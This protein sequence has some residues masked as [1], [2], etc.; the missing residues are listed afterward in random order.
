[1]HTLVLVRHGQSEW[2]R[3]NLFTGWSDVDLTSQGISEARNAGRRL[4]DDGYDFDQVFT[5]VLKRAIRT[6]W[7]ILDEMDRLW[8]P[9]DKSWR[10]NERHYGA[11]QGMNKTDAKERYGREQVQIWRRS[12][13]TRPPELPLADQRLLGNDPRYRKLPAHLLP[14]AECLH[15]TAVRFLPFWHEHINTTIRAGQ[16]VLIVAHGNS[17]RALISYLNQ[18]TKDQIMELNIPTGVPL[19][20]SLDENSQPLSMRYLSD[21][22]TIARSIPTITAGTAE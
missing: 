21:D 7:L 4:A 13:D 8:L 19:V 10:L 6:A 11:L 1:M 3:Q 5:S 15:D 14:G 9:T 18:M 20:Y 16:R 17:L 2:N 22:E 12:Y